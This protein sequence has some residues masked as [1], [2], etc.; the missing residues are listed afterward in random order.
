MKKT[1]RRIATI[2]IGLGILGALMGAESM[3]LGIGAF[4]EWETPCIAALLVGAILS[5]T[6]TAEAKASAANTMKG[7]KTT[8]NS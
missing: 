8:A 4:L 7:G 3:E 1:T 6:K 2:L 5:N